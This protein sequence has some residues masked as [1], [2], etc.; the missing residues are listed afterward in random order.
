MTKY[1][2]TFLTALTVI[3]LL[4]TTAFA[5]GT[6]VNSLERV[7]LSALTVQII[8][9]TIIPLVVGLVTRYT[10]SSGFKALMMLVLN[11]VQTLIV[12]STMADGQAIIDKSTFI[13]WVLTLLTSIGLYAGVYKPINLT[14]SSPDG[15]L[16]P[17]KGL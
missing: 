15:A 4:P 6:E 1:I 10:T 7:Q 12:Q 13:Q 17:N 9:A 14:S 5:A 8:I 16:L 2:R 11:A 3:L